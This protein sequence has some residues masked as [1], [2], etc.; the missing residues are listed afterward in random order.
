MRT[1][2]SLGLVTF[3]LCP[4]TA[5]A[6]VS[7]PERAAEIVSRSTDQTRSTEAMDFSMSFL[8]GYDQNDSEEF[9]IVD[10]LAPPVFVDA[11]STATIN[12]GL[13]YN[14]ANQTRVLGLTLNGGTSFYGG[15]QRRT[16]GRPRTS[17]E[18]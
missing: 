10:P 6:Q 17:A 13:S 11:S 1:F 9:Q 16:S 15:A 2:T 7:R 14:R 4:L 18:A 8:G 12:A 3:A 5:A